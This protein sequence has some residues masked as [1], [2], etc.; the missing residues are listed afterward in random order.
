MNFEN[1]EI[2]VSQDSL[3]HV[4][5]VDEALERLN[6]ID[7]RKSRIVLLRYYAGLT[8]EQT[9]QALGL[10]KTVVKDEWRFARAW[11]YNEMVGND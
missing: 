6:Q 1:L 11:L 8:I 3:V 9:A 5:A 2:A 10:S 4:L 7:P